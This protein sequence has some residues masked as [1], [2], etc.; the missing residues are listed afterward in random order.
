MISLLTL[1]AALALTQADR[2]YASPAPV[3][4]PGHLTT[5]DMRPRYLREASSLP[6][7]GIFEDGVITVPLR[8]RAPA[9]FN[10]AKRQNIVQVPVA[11]N[12]DFS[13]VRTYLTYS[14]DCR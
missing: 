5:R 7:R 14:R 2:G 13:Y 1:C 9:P 11:D 3:P 4:T 6:E 8:R 12:Q 10:K